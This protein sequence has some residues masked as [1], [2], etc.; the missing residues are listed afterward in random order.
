MTNL[1]LFTKLITCQ[2][3]RKIKET[4]CTQILYIYILVRR[5]I[6]SSIPAVIHAVQ[7]W[8]ELLL[9]E[10]CGEGFPACSRVSL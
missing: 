10:C 4:N 5:F 7:L 1:L 3:D 9:A 8:H 6:A 2:C